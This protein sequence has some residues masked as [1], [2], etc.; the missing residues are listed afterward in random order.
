M[1]I[2]SCHELDAEHLATPRSGDDSSV[3]GLRALG[4]DVV[5]GLR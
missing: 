5:I 3:A 4:G 1:K 2:N